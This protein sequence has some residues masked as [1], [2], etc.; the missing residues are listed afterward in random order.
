M[1]CPPVSNGSVKLTPLFFIKNLYIS[2]VPLPFHNKK[3]MTPFF[4]YNVI[5]TKTKIPKG[6]H[7]LW[8]TL[9]FIY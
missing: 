3:A 4:V 8:T 1:F 6:C 2:T 7:C 9:Y 5:T